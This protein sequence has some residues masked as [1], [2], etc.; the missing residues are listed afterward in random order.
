MTDY[1]SATQ[2]GSSVRCWRGGRPLCT[3]HVHELMK[4]LGRLCADNRVSAGHKGG[5]ARHADP[6]CFLVLG[7]DHLAMAALAQGSP[8]ILGIQSELGG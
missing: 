5:H 6:P 7:L 8:E 4:Y 1:P 3:D 2:S